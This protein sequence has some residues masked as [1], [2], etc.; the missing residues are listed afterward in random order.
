MDGLSF[1]VQQ[2]AFRLGYICGARAVFEALSEH[3]RPADS[4][5]WRDKFV[6]LIEARN[7]QAAADVE[8]TRPTM[9]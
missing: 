5:E 8:F 7:V 4:S 3:L 9:V 6:A 1:G 2:S